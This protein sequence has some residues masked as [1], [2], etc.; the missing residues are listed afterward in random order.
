MN[1]AQ[2][3]DH[4]CDLAGI[5]T[6]YWDLGGTRIEVADSTKHHLLKA[7][8]Y[9]TGSD[10]ALRSGINAI[11][12]GRWCRLLE[13]V[14]VLRQGGAA[15]ITV[16]FCPENRAH[17]LR[18]RLDC[19]NG[20]DV[21]GKLGVNE[22]EELETRRI[23]GRDYIR[24]R[25]HLPPDLPLGYHDIVLTIGGVKAA[26]RIIV[27][28]EKAYRP[29]IM[30]GHK[31]WG[32]AHQ[33][34]SLRGEKNQGIGD[35]SDLA[36]LGG[37]VAGAGGALLG[38][39]PLHAL[40]LSAPEKASPYAPSSRIFI[41]PLY[42]DITAIAEFNDCPEAR[43]G[44]Q[45]GPLAA[46]L[47]TAQ[48][49]DRVDYEAVCNIKLQIL[50]RVFTWFK[51]RAYGDR[52]AEFGR[53]TKEGGEKL[54]QFALYQA[55]EAH[56]CAPAQDWPQ[57][58]H[59]SGSKEVAAFA[60]ENPK[61][62]SFHIWLQWLAR[63]QLARA[64]AHGRK[65]GL[66]VGLY[67]D[68][69]VGVDAWGAD[70][71]G[72]DGIYVKGAVFGAPPDPFSAE[73]QNWGM[74]P[75]DPMRLRAAAYQP[76]IDILRAN[77]RHMGALRIDHVMWLQRMFWIPQ[78]ERAVQ[79]AYIRYPVDDLMRILALE[80]RRNACLVI[81]EDLGTVPEGFADRMAVYGILSYQLMRFERYP[82]GLFKRPSTYPENALAMF[83]SH[84]LPPIAG[85]W[86]GKDIDDATRPQ[87]RSELEM[88]IN[89]LRD[90]NL[91]PEHCDMAAIILAIH[92]YLARTPS[93]LMMVNLEDVLA[94]REQVNVPG[95]FLERPNW[96]CKLSA[97]AEEIK[98]RLA[99][100]GPA[101]QKERAAS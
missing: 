92:R 20:R 74:P 35:F 57:A 90:Q 100:L 65:R 21:S 18:W 5:E 41:N 84:D 58:Y 27:T 86:E 45:T 99:E 50:R 79:G 11:E 4:L 67:G 48:K 13:P 56:F 66:T 68:L 51:A 83:G 29:D 53:F 15:A 25:M 9:E 96:R 89:A 98:A 24:R 12:R 85:Y 22:L 55:L 54:R 70:A 26:S 72:S 6:S 82:G 8:G 42:I 17:E 19:E 76:F 32:A 95:T 30:N 7:M 2:L 97:G 101:L 3:L 37:A 93:A 62:I 46:A 49:A 61:E 40:F 44:L 38:L 78:G 77:M 33:L 34:Y 60:D 47:S 23:E 87:R 71:W 36:R 69:A 80:S 73:G 75:L 94:M 64:A 91:W 10:K 43:E 31:I 14:Y 16:T 88:L 39:N 1:E 59:D 63:N 28:P 52:I 81:G